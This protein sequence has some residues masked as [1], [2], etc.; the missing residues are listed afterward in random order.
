VGSDVN[1]S[2]PFSVE[3]KNEFSYTYTSPL[4]RHSVDRGNFTFTLTLFN[5]AVTNSD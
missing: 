5:R 2:P 4:Y 3:D 1:E